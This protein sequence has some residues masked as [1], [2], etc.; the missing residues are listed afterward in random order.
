MA[1]VVIGGA[2]LCG[3]RGSIFGALMG[4]LMMVM[5]RNGPNLLGVSPFRQD[6]AIGATIIPERLIT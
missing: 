1:A 5:I 2:S 4:V 6:T 3:G